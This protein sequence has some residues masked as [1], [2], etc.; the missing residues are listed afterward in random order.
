MA[1]TCQ[2][3]LEEFENAGAHERFCKKNPNRDIPFSKKG[4]KIKVDEYI[5]EKPLSSIISEIRQILTQHRSRMEIKTVEQNGTVE[6]IEII[7]RIQVRR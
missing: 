6:E 2:Y 1:K 4:T 3:C 7:A 5:K